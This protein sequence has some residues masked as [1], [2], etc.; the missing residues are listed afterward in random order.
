MEHARQLLGIGMI[1]EVRRW[2]SLSKHGRFR[3]LS[4]LFMVMVLVVL[5]LNRESMRRL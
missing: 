3:M 4:L 2:D 1:T 5:D